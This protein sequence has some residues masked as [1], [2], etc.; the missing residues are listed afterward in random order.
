MTIKNKNFVELFEVLNKYFKKHLNKEDKKQVMF[1]D[2]IKL[3]QV[4]S[5]SLKHIYIPYNEKGDIYELW[6][7]ESPHYDTEYVFFYYNENDRQV[8]YFFKD[9]EEEIQNSFVLEGYNIL[10]KLSAIKINQF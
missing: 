2:N 3:Y 1:L 5:K 4:H 8:S 7:N 10:S 9:L 6:I